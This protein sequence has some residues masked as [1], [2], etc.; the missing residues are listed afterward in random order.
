MTKGG[1]SLPR[2]VSIVGKTDAGKTTLIENLVPE[3]VKLGFRVGTVKHDVHGFEM[4][5]EGKDS[6]R[7]KKSGAVVALISSPGRVGMVRDADH[8]H[9]LAELR[10][11]FLSDVDLILTEGYKR[12]AW[13]KVEI[14]RKRLARPLLATPEEGLIAVVTDEPMPVDVPHFGLDDAAGLAAFLRQNS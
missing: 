13:P 10:Q 4:D 5:R 7:H 6:Y 2:I 1:K 12:E 14:H 3:L 9:T 11:L 8:D